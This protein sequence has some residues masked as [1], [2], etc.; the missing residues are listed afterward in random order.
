MRISSKRSHIIK[1][2]SLLPFFYYPD[3]STDD[4]DYS[5]DSDDKDQKPETRN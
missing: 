4:S 2:L 3:L 1:V 5:D